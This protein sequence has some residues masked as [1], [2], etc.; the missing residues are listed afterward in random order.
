ML[1]GCNTDSE[2]LLLCFTAKQGSTLRPQLRQ[3]GFDLLVLN[4]ILLLVLLLHGGGGLV[5]GG[6]HRPRESVHANLIQYLYPTNV[7]T[8]VL[9]ILC[10]AQNVHQSGQLVTCS[11]RQG[12]GSGVRCTTSVVLYAR[13]RL[14]LRQVTQSSLSTNELLDTDDMGVYGA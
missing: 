11:H 12:L 13:C 2:P 1:R 10:T 6:S 3:H 4:F 7:F 8:W 14:V 9:P 5:R